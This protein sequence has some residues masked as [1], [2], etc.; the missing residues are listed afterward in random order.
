MPSELKNLEILVD[1][2]TVGRVPA[3]DCPVRSLL[4]FP[5][6]EVGDIIGAARVLVAPSVCYETFGRVVAKDS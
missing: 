6:G 3:L 2:D 1:H 5:A 4:Q